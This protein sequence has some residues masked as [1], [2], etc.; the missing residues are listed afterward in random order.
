MA[1]FR[2]ITCLVFEQPDQHIFIPPMRRPIWWC[3]ASI[4]ACF[5]MVCFVMVCSVRASAIIA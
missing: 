3:R 1:R 2:S 4:I 5:V